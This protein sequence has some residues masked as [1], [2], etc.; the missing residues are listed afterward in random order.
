MP[1]LA[2]KLEPKEAL[3][4]RLLSQETKLVNEDDSEVLFS[5]G[6][7]DFEDDP[8]LRKILLA[9]LSKFSLHVDLDE[10]EIG[11]WLLPRAGV[12]YAYVVEDPTTQEVT[13]FCS[14]YSLPST[15]IG[16][17]KHKTLNAAYSYY[18]VATKSDLKTVLGDALILAFKAGF[19]VFNA[20][21]VMENETVL[22][23]LKFGIGDGNLQYYLYNWKCKTMP[24][25]QVGLVLL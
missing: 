23:D 5:G 3:R 24:A 25:K 11:H 18:H 8:S 16:N 21:D 20:L 15:V 12:V 6:A 7:Y 2:P 1:L 14:F 4:H 19:D 17:D 22:K 13:D 9:H 10:H